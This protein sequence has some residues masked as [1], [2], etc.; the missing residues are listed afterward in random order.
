MAPAG[1]GWTTWRR[2]GASSG[3]ARS[4]SPRPGGPGSSTTC[5]RATSR[6][7]ASSGPVMRAP[8]GSFLVLALAAA[9]PLLGTGTASAASSDLDPTFGTGG[10]VATAFAGPAD[11]G[12]M[13]LTPH[14]ILV[15]GAMTPAGGRSKV[16]L[17]RYRM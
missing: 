8:L 9:T 7:T 11:V 3:S 14:R 15:A 1:S 6:G 17:A 5:S 4:S 10:E 12:D 13:E 16:A 2:R